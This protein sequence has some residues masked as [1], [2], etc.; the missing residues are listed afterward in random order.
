VIRTLT[1]LK[2]WI[3]ELPE[4]SERSDGGCRCGWDADSWRDWQAHAKYDDINALYDVLESPAGHV[5]APESVNQTID[6]LFMCIDVRDLMI[7]NPDM[8]WDEAKSAA[9]YE[10]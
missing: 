6:W 1:Q 2:E 5:E 3:A 8:T 7:D 9:G 10:S 4:H